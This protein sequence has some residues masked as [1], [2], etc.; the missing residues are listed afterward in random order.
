L[1]SP[2]RGDFELNEARWWSNWALI[3]WLGSSGYLLTSK[4]FNEPFFNR[5]CILNCR[6]VDATVAWA[7][8]RLIARK[9][10]STITIFASCAKA[11]KGLEA[12]GYRPAD[13]MTVLLS[14][15]SAKPANRPAQVTINER[16]AAD[17]WTQAY[18]RAFYGDQELAPH[19]T[20][21]VARLLN[22][23]AVTLLEA[24]VGDDTVGVLAIF[25]TPGLA[26]VYCVGTIP[27]HR[28]KGVAGTL[29]SRAKAIAGAEGRHLFLQSLASDG[30][31]RYYL[32]RGFGVLYSKTLLSKEG[33][34][35]N[36]KK[37]V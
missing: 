34:Y 32:Q 9:M 7:E 6:D 30:T 11:V 28:R 15:D 1:G 13:T 21:I 33:S 35:A 20:P 31:S 27:E 24:K 37:S 5:A 29:L 4:D 18:T 16:P 14:S 2:S 12:S 36:K 8:G 3:A 17:S 19:I 25:R 10:S 22:L 26:G 23:S